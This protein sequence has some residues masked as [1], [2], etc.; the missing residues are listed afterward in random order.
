MGGLPDVVTIMEKKVHVEFMWLFVESLIHI[1]FVV[2]KTDFV[3]VVAVD[4]EF[5]MHSVWRPQTSGVM[6]DKWS[7]S[8]TWW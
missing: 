2:K 7:R 1:P 5:N 6:A 4:A 3:V 8:W